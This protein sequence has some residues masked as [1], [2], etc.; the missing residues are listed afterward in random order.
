MRIQLGLALMMCSMLCNVA[1]GQNTKDQSVAHQAHEVI[2]IAVPLLVIILVSIY[3]IKY[4]LSDLLKPSAHREMKISSEISEMFDDFQSI[5]N[6]LIF[7]LLWFV[8]WALLSF[9]L[10]YLLNDD[11]HKDFMGISL[12]LIFAAVI[13]NFNYSM[14]LIPQAFAILWHRGII[15]SKVS[16]QSGKDEISEAY[17]LEAFPEKPTELLESE[18]KAF[19]N[20]FEKRMNYLSG[21]LG[22]GVIC[23]LIGVLAGFWEYTNSEEF[24]GDYFKFHESHYFENSYFYAFLGLLV[25]LMVWRLLTESWYISLLPMSFNIS[26]QWNHPDK[27]GGLSPLGNLCLQ[28][29]LMVGIFSSFFGGWIILPQIVPF[30]AGYS[31]YSTFYIYILIISVTVGPMTFFLPVWNVHQVMV[32]KRK[33]VLLNLDQLNQKIDYLE[34]KLLYQK[35][36]I[37]SEISRKMLGKLE[38]AKNVKNLYNGIPVWPFEPIILHKFYLSI[39]LPL[40]IVSIGEIIKILIDRILGV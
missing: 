5:K 36:E 9:A 25:G 11:N 32:L 1:L 40:L 23:A 22:F 6:P 15:G 4:I 12:S 2:V 26:P 29:A 13:L 8:P 37:H 27:C 21:Q 28:N 7:S 10:Y 3:Y 35:D 24:Q 17:E 18:Y 19:I 20:N 14:T 16:E 38:V 33:I 30:F 31:Y 34:N 39:I